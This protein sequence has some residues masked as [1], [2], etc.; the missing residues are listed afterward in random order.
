[1]KEDLKILYKPFLWPSVKCFQT[2][3]VMRE[4]ERERRKKRPV[5]NITLWC[6]HAVMSRLSYTTYGNLFHSALDK[7]KAMVTV[8]TKSGPAQKHNVG[9]LFLKCWETWSQIGVHTIPLLYEQ[10]QNILAL[11]NILN[12]VMRTRVDG[13]ASFPRF[14]CIIG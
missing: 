2:R 7:V 5:K 12:C 6:Q 1:M 11:S 9:H 10:R 14:W 3:S 13:E 4:R 8:A